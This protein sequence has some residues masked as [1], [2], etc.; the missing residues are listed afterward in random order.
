MKGVLDLLRRKPHAETPDTPDSQLFTTAFADQGVDL[1]ML[2]PWEARANEIGAKRV[3]AARGVKQLQQLWAKDKYMSR[4]DPAAI[5]R[6]EKFV[7]FAHVEADRDIIRQDE[8]GNFMIVLLTGTIAVD[9]VQPWG[10]K[11]R[12]TEARPGDILGEM[13]LL[14]SGK[15]FSLCVSLTECEIAVLSAEAMDQMMAAEPQLAAGLV[16]LLARKLSMRLRV[17]GARLSDRQD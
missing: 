11:M 16:A 1:S 17:V 15:R 12:L 6:L 5:Q 7:D 14:D 2:V 9:R 10:E 3:P 4:L 8:Y 13:S